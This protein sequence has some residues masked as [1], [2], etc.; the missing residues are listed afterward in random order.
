MNFQPRERYHPY[1]GEEDLPTIFSL[2]DYEYV[3]VAGDCDFNPRVPLSTGVKR[4]CDT[5]V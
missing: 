5:G 4:S 2:D 3:D 1:L